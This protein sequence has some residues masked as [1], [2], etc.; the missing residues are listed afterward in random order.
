MASGR[1]PA[2][3]AARSICLPI[4]E[5]GASPT[6]GLGRARAQASA[7]HSEAVRRSSN[8]YDRSSPR[9]P[10]GEATWK[11]NEPGPKAGARRRSIWEAVPTCSRGA[12]CEVGRIFLIIKFGDAVQR[13]PR[14]Q[15]EF[16]ER[17]R[18]I[19]AGAF[20]RAPTAA[21][22]LTFHAT[23]R[24]L[25]CPFICLSLYFS[26]SITKMTGRLIVVECVRRSAA[27]LVCRRTLRQV[28]EPLQ[29]RRLRNRLQP[30]RRSQM[31]P[32]SAQLQ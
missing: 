16:Y 2:C 14:S 31:R 12:N 26:C 7:A 11:P 3:P 1:A 9:S 28:Q 29:L 23:V 25:S 20:A 21:R 17:P 5:Q 6:S 18:R 30:N 32:T 27:S 10:C 13:R 4:Q 15:R 22:R 24:N 19:L 8:R